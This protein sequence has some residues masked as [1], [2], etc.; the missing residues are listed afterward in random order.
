[1]RIDG[2]DAAFTDT[3]DKPVPDIYYLIQLQAQKF[4]AGFSFIPRS[5]PRVKK[6]DLVALTTN[7]ALNLAIQI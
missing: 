3:H 1:M 7:Y 5:D 2:L 4:Q 6:S